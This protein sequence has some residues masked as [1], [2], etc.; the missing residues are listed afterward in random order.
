[1]GLGEQCAALDAQRDALA[2]RIAET[3]SVSLGDKPSLNDLSAALGERNS[4]KTSYRVVSSGE[5][6]NSLRVGDFGKAVFRD[7]YSSAY[8]NGGAFCCLGNVGANFGVASITAD[9]VFS[10]HAS[11]AAAGSA[12]LDKDG[13]SP[14]KYICGTAMYLYSDGVFSKFADIVHVGGCTIMSDFSYDFSGF[15]VYQSESVGGDWRYRLSRQH[16]SEDG[17]AGEKKDTVVNFSPTG[18][19]RN[20]NLRYV[21]GNYANTELRIYL[22]DEASFGLMKVGHYLNS[23]V[24]IN[25]QFLSELLGN[26]YFAARRDADGKHIILEFNGSKFSIKWEFVDN[27][28]SPNFISGLLIDYESGNVLATQPYMTDGTTNIFNSAT[29]NFREV[30]LAGSKSGLA[31][32]G[33]KIPLEKSSVYIAGSTVTTAEKG[34]TVYTQIR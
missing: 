28:S 32:N 1:M 29:G 18:F 4:V 26:L 34:T 6:P 5:I 19:L 8:V 10:F 31:P 27:P 9:G 16:V 20:G 22:M 25:V 3:F 33:K 12:A 24:G 13:V 15:Y 2:K 7:G 11:P 21:F 14:A 23:S 30:A 17:V